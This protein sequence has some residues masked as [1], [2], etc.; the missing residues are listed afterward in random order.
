MRFLRPLGVLVVAPLAWLGVAAGPAGAS[1]AAPCVICVTAPDT[2][3]LIDGTGDDP[4][5]RG[6]VELVIAL[7]RPVA[8]RVAVEVSYGTANGTATAPADYTP[9]SGGTVTIASGETVGYARVLVSRAALCSGRSFD[10]G[11]YAPSAGRLLNADT[12]VVI[13]GRGC[14]S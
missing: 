2:I 7:E 5:P 1:G 12:R 3:Y 13:R 6:Y 8:S 4:V 14:P 11:F 10:V 9:V